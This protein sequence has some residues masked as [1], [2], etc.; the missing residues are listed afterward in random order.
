M[1]LNIPDR[2][3]LLVISSISGAC[4]FAA[5]AVLWIWG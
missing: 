1:T 3:A 4:F 5:A 2:N